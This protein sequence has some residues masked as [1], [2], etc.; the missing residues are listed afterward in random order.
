LVALAVATAGS[1]VAMLLWALFRGMIPGI[2]PG[3]P[4]EDA[5][6]TREAVQFATAEVIR[7]ATRESLRATD[8]VIA[9]ATATTETEIA[10]ERGTA[11]ARTSIAQATRAY[12][13]AQA[14]VTQTA[15]AQAL[16]TT[17]AHAEETV[18]A[19]SAS[20]TQVYGPSNGNLEPPGGDQ[21]ACDEAGLTLHNFI[22]EARF[23]NPGPES[24]QPWDYGIIFPNLGTET[25]YRLTVSSDGD[26]A[27]NLHS[28]GFD[29]TNRD[30]T[31]LLDVSEGGSN[32]LK[33]VVTEEGAYLFING[34]YVT[35]L[36]LDM[37]E[38][39]SPD[40]AL[41]PVLICAGVKS[42]YSVPGRATRYEDFTV[43]SLP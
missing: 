31:A 42:G 9:Q 8:T 34:R 2:G 19:L 32:T 17:R 22:A 21:V 39:V 35:T 4:E 38:I 15:R 20:A 23:Y 12:A 13:T 7:E 6:A 33:L 1:I 26:W 10:H 41:H 11:S 43:W 27:L 25:D 37:F 24:G 3:Q 30:E 5:S 18:T 36:D 14:P 29:I 16:E 40:R 28:T